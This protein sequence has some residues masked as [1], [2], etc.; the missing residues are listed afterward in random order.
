MQVIYNNVRYNPLENL[1]FEE[2]IANSEERYKNNK[3]I[4]LI[5]DIFMLEV[6]LLMAFFN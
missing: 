4:T 6:I 1:S 3:N 2:A 5:L